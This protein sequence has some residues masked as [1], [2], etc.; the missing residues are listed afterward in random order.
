MTTW[1]KCADQMPADTKDE[2]IFRFSDN[3]APSHWC[4]GEHVN[5]ISSEDT[6]YCMCEW[7]AY[8]PQLWKELN[9]V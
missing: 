7:T 8:T 3:H 4:T 6:F 2:Y 5:F 1:I 9:N